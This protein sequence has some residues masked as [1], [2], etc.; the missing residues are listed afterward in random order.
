MDW[1]SRN[2]GSSLGVPISGLFGIYSLFL[3]TAIIGFYA[4]HRLRAVHEE[5]EV[6]GRVV[7][8]HLLA[9]LRKSVRQISRVL[10]YGTVMDSPQS[11]PR[12]I[13]RSDPNYT[14]GGNDA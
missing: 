4:M 7:V 8:A 14:L 11:P 1:L 5:H 6:E 2:V 9:E 13:F 10:D 3:I 12:K